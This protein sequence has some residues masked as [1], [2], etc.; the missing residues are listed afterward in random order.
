MRGFLLKK[1]LFED[2]LNAYTKT[3][4]FLNTL[5][6]YIKKDHHRH[7]IKKGSE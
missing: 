4:R 3:H 5:S 1:D 6:K 7:K 2:K